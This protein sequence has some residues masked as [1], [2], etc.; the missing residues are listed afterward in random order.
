MEEL[1]DW[2]AIASAL[3]DLVFVLT[4]SGRYAEILGGESPEQFHNAVNLKGMSLYDVLPEHKADWFVNRINETLNADKLM[5]YEYSLSAY[6]VEGVDAVSGPDGELRFEGR[7]CPLK[8][9]RYGEKAVVWVA[10][11]I[12]ERYELEQQL[13]YQSEFDPLTNALNRRKLFKCLDDSLL[14]FK[15]HKINSSFILIDIDNFKA[16]N[17]NLGH[18]AGDKVICD[19]V[20]LCQ[21]ELKES[22][23]FGRIGGDEFGIIYRGTH[24]AALKFSNYLRELVVS[25]TSEQHISMSVGISQFQ[26]DDETIDQV[27]QRSDI[28]LYKSKRAGK[29]IST[30]M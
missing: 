17:D 19:L 7:V 13:I 24:N 11:N 22:D 23:L 27:Y 2:Q 5:I 20:A 10:R 9:T 28:A 3:P 8:T 15:R 25:M 6:D 16:V 21:S 29:N 18:Q 14:S 4:D 26:L 30:L 12:S 1:E